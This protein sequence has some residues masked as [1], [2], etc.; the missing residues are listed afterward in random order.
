MTGQSDPGGAQ[1]RGSSGTG[2]GVITPDGCAVDLYALLPAGDDP[3]IIHAAVPG[4]ASILELGSG[5]GRVTSALIALGHPVVAVDESAEMLARVRGAETVLAAIEDLSLGRL[6]DVALLA[7]HL[8]NVPDDATRRALLGTCARHIAPHGCVIIQQHP[9]AWFD[10]AGPSERTSPEGITFRLRDV[11]RPGP[12]L[13]AATV[14][15]EAGSRSWTQSFI[16]RRLSDEFLRACLQD[17]GL[18][19]DAYVTGDHAWLR[20]VPG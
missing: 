13:V 5:T 4:G 10:S 1:I 20:A 14:V 19:L 8:I 18:A 11:T 16:T 2:P 12:G 9:P 7:S 3:G 17:A 6:F 15:Y